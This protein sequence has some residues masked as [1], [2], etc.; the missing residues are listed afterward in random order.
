MNNLLF[1]TY[2][3]IWTAHDEPLSEIA[4]DAVNTCHQQGQR[5]YISPFS[6]WELGILVSKGRL[7]LSL[8]PS[9]LFEHYQMNGHCRLADLNPKILA[10]ASFLP[11]K[12]SDDPADQILISTARAMD[13]TLITR[14][15]AI[16]D[17]GQ[18]DWVRV[19]AC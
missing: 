17:H 1:D 5:L 10:K 6:T 11:G 14:D 16:K 18:E 15:R 7:R 19:L 9:E 13:L 12:P 2:A 3:V 8:P 4:G